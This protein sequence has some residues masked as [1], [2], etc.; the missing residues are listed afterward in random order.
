MPTFPVLQYASTSWS[1]STVEKP[2]ARPFS[3][4]IT[5]LGA[6]DSLAP[7]TVGHPCDCPVPGDCECMTANPRGTHVPTCD[8]EMTGWLARCR[9]A[10]GYGS[11]AG[12]AS[13]TSCRR[14]Q[15]WSKSIPA[16]PE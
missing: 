5:A 11:R 9:I 16:V 3:Q 4:S 10:G 13:P 15:K 2:R 14:L 8:R 12:G 6:S 1:P 7:P